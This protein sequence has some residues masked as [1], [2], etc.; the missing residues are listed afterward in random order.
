MIFLQ[1]NE[2][3]LEV[4]L[5]KYFH[6]T[7]NND[8]QIVVAHIDDN[9]TDPVCYVRRNVGLPMQKFK[10]LS[11][12]VDCLD[13]KSLTT[14]FAHVLHVISSE[15]ADI[16]FLQ[17]VTTDCYQT[18]RREFEHE[19]SV[20]AEPNNMYFCVTLWKID[21]F[22]KLQKTCEHFPTSCMGRNMLITE[23]RI[24]DHNIR[25]YLINTHL[26]STIDHKVERM[27]QT[28]TFLDRIANIDGV[29]IAG[30]DLNMRDS[31]LAQI[32]GLP[33]NVHDLWEITGKRPEC[34]FTWDSKRN[35]NIT[36]SGGRCRFDRLLFKNTGD[37][38]NPVRF[39]LTGIERPRS[40]TMFPSDHWAVQCI[41]EIN[42]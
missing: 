12:N 22:I 1:S 13:K 42:R 7:S 26:E 15:H 14:R 28:R 38:L 29:V 8:D 25:L 5:S 2:W 17:E 21:H 30:G 6:A 33:D 39:E 31:E 27:N 20:H 35:S 9:Q 24:P 19:Y 40:C 23:L 4:A 16:V 3:N 41:F 10:V 36:A 37:I 11:W 32:G 34:T 18:L